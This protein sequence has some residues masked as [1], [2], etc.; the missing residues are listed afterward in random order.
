MNEWYYIYDMMNTTVEMDLVKVATE[1][2]KKLRT[3][4]RAVARA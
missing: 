2:R 1:K 4:R 3:V